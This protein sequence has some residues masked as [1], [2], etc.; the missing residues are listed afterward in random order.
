MRVTLD[1]EGGDTVSEKTVHPPYLLDDYDIIEAKTGINYRG[2]A[3]W[4]GVDETDRRIAQAQVA[5]MQRWRP[6]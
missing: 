3:V 1:P 4:F 2:Q 5:K 6:S